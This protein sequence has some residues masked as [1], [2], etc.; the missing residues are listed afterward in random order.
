MHVRDGSGSGGIVSQMKASIELKAKATTT[1]PGTGLNTKQK[2]NVSGA[3]CAGYLGIIL[4]IENCRL[5]P[6]HVS[7]HLLS[8]YTLFVGRRSRR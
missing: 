5:C 4:K 2:I 3:A 6:P 1:S 7:S 8:T